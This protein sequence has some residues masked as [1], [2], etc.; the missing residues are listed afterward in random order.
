MENLAQHNR[1]YAQGR[2]D[3]V[4]FDEDDRALAQEDDVIQRRGTQ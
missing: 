1:A 4:E 3:S 2:S